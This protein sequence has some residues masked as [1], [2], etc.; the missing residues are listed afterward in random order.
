MSR[1]PE[2]GGPAALARV[3]ACVES[4]DDY[5]MLRMADD[6]AHQMGLTRRDCDETVAFID[7]VLRDESISNADLKGLLNRAIG[8]WGVTSP[9]GVNAEAARRHLEAARH[10]ISVWDGAIS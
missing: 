9:Y 8:A 1:P 4:V 6:F 10:A 7:R 5:S 3:L 2:V